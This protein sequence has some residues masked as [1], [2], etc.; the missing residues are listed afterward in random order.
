MD[1]GA[2]RGAGHARRAASREAACTSRCTTCR[3]GSRERRTSHGLRLRRRRRRDASDSRSSCSGMIEPAPG[4]RHGLADDAVPA[5]AASASAT[6]AT[7]SRAHGATPQAFI[8]T[9]TTTRSVPR[10]RS[11]TRMM[12]R[13][14]LGDRW[15]F[16]ARHPTAATTGCRSSQVKQLY[17][18]GDAARQPARRDGAA[19][20][21]RRDRATR[22]RRHRSRAARDRA[23]SAGAPRRSS[24]SS[25]TRRS[26][27]G[28]RTTGSRTAGS[29]SRRGFTFHAD[30]AAD[31]HRPVG[32]DDTATP[33]TLHHDRWMA[34]AVARRD[35]RGRGLSLEQAL[36]VPEVPRA[37]VAD[38]RRALRA[39]AGRATTT[40]DRRAARAARLA[41]P[42]RR[43]RLSA[44][45]I[46]YRAV[47]R[48]LARRVHRREGPE[49]AAAQRLVQRPQRHLSRRGR[50]VVTQETGFSNVFPTGRGLFGFSTLDEAAAAVD[51]IT[52][53][54]RT[55]R[56]GRARIARRVFRSRSRSS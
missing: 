3:R 29:R 23:A 34:A 6:S 39:G 49:R 10:R 14:D 25:R 15:A 27:R 33:R 4:G 48:P 5:R 21:A 17:S 50:P 20:G 46:L 13:F 19:A 37:A 41:D 12:R 2:T 22:L 56:R 32:V 52:S 55:S 42:R 53:D 7:T 18:V 30:A 54:Y 40:A 35:V 31:R 9:A 28:P 11:S 26:S 38:E 16:H 24:S 47:H 1:H 44:T 51:A 43:G 45:S 36:R 8:G